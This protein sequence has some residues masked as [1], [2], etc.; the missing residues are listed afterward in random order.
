MIN[1]YDVLYSKGLAKK[2]N[3]I[4]GDGSEADLENALMKAGWPDMTDDLSQS[5]TLAH[6]GHPLSHG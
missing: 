3:F 1:Y 4:V 2:E 6:S 5:K